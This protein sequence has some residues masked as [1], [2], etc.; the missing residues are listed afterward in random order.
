MKTKALILDLDGTLYYQIG[1]QFTM[2]IWMI[3]YYTIHFWRFKE[4][5]AIMYYRKIREKNIKEIVDIQ[6]EIVAKKYKKPIENIK[7]IINEWMFIKPLKVI[8]KFK[9]KKLAQIVDNYKDKIK[10][11]IYSDYPTKDKL[12]AIDIY[13]DKAYDSTNKLIKVLKPDVKGIN[14][15]LKDNQLKPEEILFIGDRDSKDG[16]CARRINASYIILPK[17][18]RK[19]KYKEIITIL[20]DAN[21]N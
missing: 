16:E 1:V 9:D 21:E 5:L 15:I 3:L 14:Y 4:L 17:F 20:G 2:G 8:K 6:Y 10:I 11:I 19:R 12:K 7:D 18:R 13:Y